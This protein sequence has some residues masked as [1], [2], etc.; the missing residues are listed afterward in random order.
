MKEMMSLMNETNTILK[1]RFK[2]TSGKCSEVYLEKFRLL[3][4][5][6][7]LHQIGKLFY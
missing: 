1:G 4:D 2:L 5:P 3:E 6:K 7:I